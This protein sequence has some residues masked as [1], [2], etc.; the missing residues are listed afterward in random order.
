MNKGME[1]ETGRRIRSWQDTREFG[2]GSC[3]LSFQFLQ[4]KGPGSGPGREEWK[5]LEYALKVRTAQYPKGS[6]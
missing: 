2:G 1:S 6:W 3:G 5:N 4:V